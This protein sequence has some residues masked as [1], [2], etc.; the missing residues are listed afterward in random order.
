MLVLK[1]LRTKEGKRGS[2]STLIFRFFFCRWPTAFIPSLLDFDAL[3][4]IDIDSGMRDTAPRELFF[5]AA[6]LTCPISSERLE[7]STMMQVV[8]LFCFYLLPDLV[9][10]DIRSSRDTGGKG[11]VVRRGGERRN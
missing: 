9:S 11:K 5:R 10:L 4:R 1:K 3:S 6:V 2:Q 7:E 8:L